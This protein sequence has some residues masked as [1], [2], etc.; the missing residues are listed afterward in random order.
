[1]TD[2]EHRDNGCDP[3]SGIHY[4]SPKA[5]TGFL[6]LT[7]ATKKRLRGFPRNEFRCKTDPSELG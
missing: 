5:N 7:G 1:M 2:E 3:Q 6:E 4:Y